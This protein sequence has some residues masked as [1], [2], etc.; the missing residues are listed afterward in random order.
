MPSESVGSINQYSLFFAAVFMIA[1]SA[2]R[3]S[4][5]E[6]VGMEILQDGKHVAG[7]TVTYTGES[8]AEIWLML[9][10]IPLT[11]ERD[12]PI[13]VNAENSTKATLSGSIEIRTHRRGDA[14]TGTFTDYLQLVRRG[15]AQWYVVEADVDRTLKAAG[16][17][18]PEP[19]P[20]PTT[21]WTGLYWGA[22]V[23]L[24]GL[25]ITAVVLQA[26]RRGARAE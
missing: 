2:H 15:S 17:E 10:D 25:V 16:L 21:V 7:F 11:F 12:F 8:E 13:R 24:A 6:A 3:A 4:A 14:G 20:T 5:A 18:A 23:C 9:K 1:L 26:F 22:A 19:L